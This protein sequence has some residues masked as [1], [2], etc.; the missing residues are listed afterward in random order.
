VLQSGKNTT[1]DQW[2]GWDLLGKW[3]PEFF[4]RD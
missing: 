1:N 2:N 4:T 3:L